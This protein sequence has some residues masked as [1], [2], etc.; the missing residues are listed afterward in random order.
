MRTA[1]GLHATGLPTN[2][3]FQCFLIFQVYGKSALVGLGEIWMVNAG[4]K[5]LVLAVF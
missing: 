1:A 2:T 3:P 4:L 5:I